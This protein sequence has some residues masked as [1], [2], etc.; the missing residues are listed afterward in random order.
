MFR[1]FAL[2]A[3]VSLIAAPAIAGDGVPIVPFDSPIR[4]TPHMPQ[5]VGADHPFAGRIAVDPVVGMPDRIG[6]FLNTF[7]RPKELN[8]ALA[9][10]IAA[11]GLAAVDDAAAPLR[12]KTTWIAFDSPFKI[13]FSSRASATLRYELVRRGTGEV[14][15]RRDVT[16]A[17]KASG[18]NAADRQR[19]TARAVISANLAGA[20][21]CIEQSPARAAPQDC[22]VEPVGQFDAPIIVAIPIYR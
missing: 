19:G 16:T 13:S 7:V 17:A 3:A 21:W 5:V 9:A 11:A 22:A 14:I 18:G 15:F 6:A 4:F 10:S 12:L 20:I 8:A 1:L 2:A